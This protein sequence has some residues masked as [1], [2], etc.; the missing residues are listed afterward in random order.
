MGGQEFCN[1]YQAQLKSELKELWESFS[2]HNE[3][4]DMEKMKKKIEHEKRY[5]LYLYTFSLIFFP[6]FSVK[7][8]LQCFPH[9]SGAVRPGL[10]AVC[11]LRRVAIH[12][13]RQCFLHVRLYAG[14]GHD[15]NAHLGIHSLLWPV[16]KCRLGHRPDC[17]SVTGASMWKIQIFPQTDLS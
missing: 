3:V 9:P 12:W 5:Y 4:R 16:P 17:R 14:P 1:R 15:C 6:Q 10:P 7:E 2:K 8:C 13:P 11:A